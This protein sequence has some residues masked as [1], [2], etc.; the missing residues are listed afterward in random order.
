MLL[1]LLI[2]ITFISFSNFEL[3]SQNSITNSDSLFLKESIKRGL[4]LDS[5]VRNNPSKQTSS[6]NASDTASLPIGICK[7]IGEIIYII[8]I[9]SARFT[10][11]GATFDVYMAVDWPGAYG[12]LAFAAKGVS[13]NP[14]GVTPG[15]DG[16]PITLKLLGDQKLN[17][18]PKN[19]IVFHGDGSNYIQ[20][21]C[22]GYE[23]MN[24]NAD[25]L[26]SQS[27]IHKPNGGQ[28]KAN[29]QINVEDLS[30]IMFQT[31]VDPFVINGLDDYEF[32][33]NQLVIDRNDSINP[34]GIN[35]PMAT[36]STYPTIGNWMGFYAHNITVKLPE[37]L[38]RKNGSE[39]SIGVNDLVIDENG[40]SGDFFA[41]GILSPDEGDMDNWSFSLD[42]I[43][44]GIEYNHLVDGRLTG[45]IKIEPLNNTAVAYRAAIIRDTNNNITYDFIAKTTAT[46]QYYL[47]AFDSYLTLQ[48]NC[49]I[50]VQVS[51][52]KFKPDITLN[53]FLTYDK[54]KAKLD[55]LA[56][57]NLKIG[58]T[59]PYIY[60]GTFSLTST[61]GGANTTA[62]LPISLTSLALGINQGNIVLSVGIALNLGGENSSSGSF[63]AATTVSIYTKRQVDSYSGREKLVYDKFKIND[64]SL[65]VN[66]SII[67]L[68]GILS[69]RDDDPTYGDMFYGSL[70]FKINTIMNDFAGASVGFGKLNGHRYWYVDASVPVS[71]PIGQFAL[72]TNLFGGVQYGV[73]STLTPQQKLD[74]AFSGAVNPAGIVANNSSIPFV[75]NASMGLGFSAGAAFVAIPGESVLNGEAIFSIQFNSNGGLSNINFLGKVTMLI[76]R[77]ERSSG[78]VAKVEGIISVNYD[79]VNKIFHATVD[80]NAVVPSVLTGNCNL[81]IHIDPNNWYFWLNRPSNRASVNVFNLF[82]AQTYFMVGTQIDPI[83]APP[84]YVTNLISPSPVIAIDYSQIST[85][86][87]F[88]T[89]FMIGASFGGEFPKTGNWRGYASAGIGGG[90]DITMFKLSPTAHCSGVSGKLGFNQWYIVGQVYA[91]LNGSMGARHYKDDGTLKKEYSIASINAAALLQGRLP[92]PTF[93]YGA[94]AFEVRLLG[95]ISFDFN[96]DI[97]VGN[98][99][100]IVN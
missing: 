4:T 21:G 35:L 12:K 89:G 67:E 17:L 15:A 77:S 98:G 38:S 3:L 78:N 62:R 97:E 58:T 32:R 81:A 11:Q 64:I 33:I 72:I 29:L 88:A 56:F 26:F 19:S 28:V 22:N 100:T 60:S 2:F 24:I 34:S 45:N 69:I 36:Q 70:S 61:P 6:F 5:I 73:E 18:G 93:V 59:A 54:A 51:N 83:P 44:L 9:D 41:S 79:N 92:K 80:A 42:T 84:S 14:K 91:W 39:T 31:T 57:Q 85:G 68:Y 74:K 96:A 48:P 43:L 30:K 55:K 49:Q 86:Q 25:I 90:F 75:P 50:H 82:T 23:R 52:N 71:I 95:I 37:K 7:K 27:L 94:I 10:P 46:Q 13:F 66:T 65:S 63:A 8:C 16:N 76:M 47:N 53:G 99:C 40:V 20:W 87:G 1:R